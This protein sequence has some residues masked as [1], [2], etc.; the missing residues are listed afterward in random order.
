M[1]ICNEITA[2]MFSWHNKLA[3]TP[4]NICLPNRRRRRVSTK[5]STFDNPAQPSTYTP[6]P[7]LSI[8]GFWCEI[9]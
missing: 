6:A 4:L 3:R 7:S 2:P 1:R 9:S 8:V 5:R